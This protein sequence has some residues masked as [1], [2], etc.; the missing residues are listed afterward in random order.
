VRAIAATNRKKLIDGPNVVEPH[1]ATRIRDKRLSRA[2]VP[3]RDSLRPHIA[4][5]AVSA[6]AFFIA[7]RRF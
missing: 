3:G 1:Q 2:V 5:I 6:A 4:R 7:P